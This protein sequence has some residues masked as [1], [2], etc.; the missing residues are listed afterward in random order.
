MINGAHII[1]YSKDAEADR[2]FFKDVLGF[3]S[4]DAGHG[5]LI[6]SLPPA[7]V[8][9]HPADENN[10]HEFYLMCDDLKVTMSAL[11][12]KG[13]YV[14]SQK[15]FR[16]DCLP[17]SNF[18]AAANLVSTSR[19]MRGRQR[20]EKLN[21]NSN[22]RKHNGCAD[23]CPGANSSLISRRSRGRDGYWQRLPIL[24]TQTWIRTE[25][26]RG[27]GILWL[28]RVGPDTARRRHQRARK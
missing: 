10:D 25:P 20:P 3:P 12:A 23:E 7:E 16:G 9:C 8:A 26:L 15:T 28:H 27:F 2:A 14:P 19:N 4:V 6:F 13:V 21:L 11:D 22:G 5:W 24:R 18:L 1:I 17:G